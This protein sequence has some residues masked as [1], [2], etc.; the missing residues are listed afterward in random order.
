MSG[1]ELFKLVH[2]AYIEVNQDYLKEQISEACRYCP[3]N[4]VNGGS[5]VCNCILGTPVIC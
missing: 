2:N 3:N 1:E 4:P 5:G